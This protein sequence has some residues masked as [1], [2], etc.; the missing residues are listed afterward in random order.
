MHV[1][2]KNK[3]LHAR[4]VQWLHG[5]EK[6]L[7]W[8][9]TLLERRSS[10]DSWVIMDS[11]CST[12]HGS[13]PGF[14]GVWVFVVCFVSLFTQSGQLAKFVWTPAFYL[15]ARI[16]SAHHAPCQPSSPPI[17]VFCVP[18][19]PDSLPHACNQTNWNCSP[20]G[21][22]RGWCGKPFNTFICMPW[23][24]DILFSVFIF[25]RSSRNG[26]LE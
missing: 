6:I 20:A 21:L 7:A 10:H 12:T 22:A 24:T 26:L 14:W 11:W 8:S 17:A 15:S 9:H 5:T 25:F 2:K 18:R 1:S 4:S 13:R 16:P 19:E 3:A 23:K